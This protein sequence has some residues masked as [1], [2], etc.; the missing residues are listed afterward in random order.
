MNRKLIILV[1]G[2][3]IV[4]LAVVLSFVPIETLNASIDLSLG[5]LPLGIY[6]VRRGVS[7]GV[8]AG[9]CWGILRMFF[10]GANFLTLPQYILDYPIAFL[11]IGL[12][13][14]FSKQIKDSLTQGKTLNLT[15]FTIL[16]GILGVG[17]RWSMHYISGATVFKEYAPPE[18]SPFLY[19]LIYNL[20]SF[21]MNLAYFVIIFIIM[22]KVNNSLIFPK[23]K[24]V[25]KDLSNKE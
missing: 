11:C 24:S 16:S 6:S 12:I 20:P 10:A 9:L 18:Q 2:S 4:T 14:V 15:I 8:L 5:I 22:V 3:I 19:S 7:A 13:G 17:G 23:D 21:L 25:P 1:E